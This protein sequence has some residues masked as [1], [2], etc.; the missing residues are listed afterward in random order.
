M[1]TPE[2]IVKSRV[3]DDMSMPVPSAV[4]MR[5]FPLSVKL[6]A[7]STTLRPRTLR[8][9]PKV[10]A[11]APAAFASKIAVSVVPG[12][13]DSNQFAVF[14]HAPSVAPVHVFAAFAN[15]DVE[16]ITARMYAAIALD[17]LDF[18]GIVGWFTIKISQ[19]SKILA[20]TLSGYAISSFA[21]RS[22]VLV[23]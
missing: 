20:I 8:S 21:W 7:G 23:G 16:V 2:L 4:K 19:D 12:S 15:G 17:F 11:R 9:A 6:P 10:M 22:F 14:A 5:L 3:A 1:P 13:A 18:I